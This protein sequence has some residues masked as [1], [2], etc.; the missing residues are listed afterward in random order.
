MRKN[1]G[2]DG[3]AKY[4]HVLPCGNEKIELPGC[5]RKAME[6]AL[7]YMRVF[8]WSE[9]GRLQYLYPDG[10]LPAKMGE[11]LDLIES[12]IDARMARKMEAQEN[13]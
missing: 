3:P 9:K 10:E 12:Q 4:P 5:P 1:L 11:G 2:C 13:K 8:R 7:D 6:P